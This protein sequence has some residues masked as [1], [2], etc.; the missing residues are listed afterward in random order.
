MHFGNLL[1]KT[2]KEHLWLFV[3]LLLVFGSI[4][5]IG[6]FALWLRSKG[7]ITTSEALRLVT[8]GAL[9]VI[10]AFYA[11]RTSAI[12]SAS[13][14]QAENMQELVKG[15]DAQLMSSLKLALAA[16]DQAVATQALASQTERQV[17]STRRLAKNAERQLQSALRPILRFKD[18]VTLAEEMKLEV[19][20]LGSG[21]AIN[22]KCWVEVAVRKGGVIRKNSSDGSVTFQ[23]KVLPAGGD[24]RSAGIRVWQCRLTPVPPNAESV[25]YVAVYQDV[26]HNYFRSEQRREVLQGELTPEQLTIDELPKEQAEEALRAAGY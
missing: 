1:R 10:T 13:A 17:T 7:E 16:Q 15:T 5:A 22:I 23:T 25:S 11:V 20:N 26:Y 6:V 19:S 18:N 4:A 9:V 8:L 14:R 24:N 3:N 2:D 21:P 12:A